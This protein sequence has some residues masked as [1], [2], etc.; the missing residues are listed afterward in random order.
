MIEYLFYL[1]LLLINSYDIKFKDL[2]ELKNKNIIWTNY[3]DFNNFD[4]FN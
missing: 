2:C 4:D 1:L 3:N